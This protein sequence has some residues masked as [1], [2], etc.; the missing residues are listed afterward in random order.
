DAIVAALAMRD[1]LER[2]N[3]RLADGL[4][5]MSIGIG[6]HAG[7]V[8]AGLIGSPQKR[9]YTV[10]GDVVNTASRLEGMTKQLGASILVTSAVLESQA[11][12]LAAAPP[13]PEWAGEI[14]LAEK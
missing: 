7:E 3:R 8:V 11:K 14:A 4:P 9:E 12:S 5:P 13:P 1:E 6:L 2:F 10:I